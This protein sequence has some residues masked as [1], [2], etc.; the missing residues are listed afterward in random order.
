MGH[1]Q[2]ARVSGYICRLCSEV[3]RVVILLY[4]DVGLKL[5][6][7]AK[8]NN[9][10]N[11]NIKPNDQLP[12]TVCLNCVRQVEST[13]RF[14]KKI[15]KNR[16]IF[17]HGREHSLRRV[18]MDSIAPDGGQ[19]SSTS[20]AGTSGTSSTTSAP[21]PVDVTSEESESDF[22]LDDLMAHRF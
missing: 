13:H 11:I 15:L 3:S 21:N 2:E 18:Q 20:E 6:L 8:I 12:K 22:E 9:F 16:Q 1:M 10:L 7:V 4:G 14:I 5:C 19:S 17:K